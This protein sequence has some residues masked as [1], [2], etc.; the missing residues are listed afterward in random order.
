LDDP[1]VL[2]VVLGIMAEFGFIIVDTV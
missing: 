1:E 2:A